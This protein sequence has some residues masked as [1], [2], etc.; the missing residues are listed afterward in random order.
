[1]QKLG[2]VFRWGPW[3]DDRREGASIGGA[4]IAHVRNGLASEM[5][6]RWKDKEFKGAF[7]DAGD[8]KRRDEAERM[9]ERASENTLMFLELA[10]ED[11]YQ[12]AR[13]KVVAMPDTARWFA[14]SS[15]R[16]LQE[17]WAAEGE[18]HG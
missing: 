6:L 4:K 2:K 8:V 14:C 9:L 17:K 13:K 10:D 5:S 12:R 18:S 1:M 11:D 16:E 3:N 15:W 7:L